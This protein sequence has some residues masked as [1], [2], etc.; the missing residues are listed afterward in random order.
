[1]TRKKNSK[2][3]STIEN[4][5]DFMAKDSVKVSI[6]VILIIFT[7]YLVISLISFLISGYADQSTYNEV[8]NSTSVLNKGGQI[9]SRLSN[10]LINKWLGL[11]IFVFCPILL[12]SGLKFIGVYKKDLTK[13][14]LKDVDLDKKKD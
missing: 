4:I 8:I 9:G 6:G 2:N 10:L 11:A 3:N 12:A 13:C 14:K 7:I 1:M 5:K